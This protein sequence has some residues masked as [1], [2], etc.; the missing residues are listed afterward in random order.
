MFHTSLF[1]RRF[2]VL[3]GALLSASLLHAGDLSKYRA[4]QFG[5]DLTRVADVGGMRVSDAK[6]IYQHPALVQELAWRTE[7]SQPY[8]VSD[9]VT[10]VE[11]RFYNGELFRMVVAYDRYKTRGMTA[12]DMIDAISVIYGV[13]ARPP[14]KQASVS[15]L[16]GNMDVVARWEDPQFLCNL[17]HPANQPAFYLVLLSKQLDALARPAI[18][19]G[20]RIDAVQGPQRELDLR[21]KQE[22]D[23][24]LQIEKAR[25]ANKATF[26]T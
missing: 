20:I 18:A 11:L 7:R 26:Q 2:A 4:F 10:G 16:Q 3:L 9:S 6:V 19:A 23:L 1:A 5:M 8:S 25:L 12:E 13:A 21:K 22:E 14:D 24:L 17:L 15:A